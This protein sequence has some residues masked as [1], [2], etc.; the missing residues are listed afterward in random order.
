M[1]KRISLIP[2]APMARILLN[3]GAERVSKDAMYYF[4]DLV[5]EYALEVSRKALMIAQHSGRKTIKAKDL[6]LA[7]K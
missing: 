4:G 7:I 1:P 6:Q 3:A 2:K 5:E